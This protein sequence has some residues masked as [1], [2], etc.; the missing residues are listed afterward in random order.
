MIGALS[1]NFLEGRCFGR[2]TTMENDSE[3]IPV[4]KLQSVE[5][6]PMY[7]FKVRVVL[8]AGDLW[9]YVSGESVKPTVVEGQTEVASK[10]Y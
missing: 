6:W 5:K 7:N 4:D 2:F 1:W 8:S 3:K 9:E 10:H